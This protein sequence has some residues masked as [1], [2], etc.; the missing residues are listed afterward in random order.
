MRLFHGRSALLL[1]PLIFALPLL[2]PALLPGGPKALAQSPTSP[3]HAASTTAGAS[4][5]DAAG[6]LAKAA[7]AVSENRL[8]DARA[9][10]DAVKAQNS[11]QPGL[12]TAYAA[13]SL[14]EGD[15]A[16]AGADCRK[17]LALYPARWDAYRLL[18]TAEL[19]AG[20]QTEAIATLRAW[21]EADAANPQP[22]AALVQMLLADGKPAEALREGNAGLQRLPETVRGDPELQ[23]ALGAGELQAGDRAKGTSMLLA[24]LRGTEDSAL[25][26]SVAYLL[27]D[28]HLELPL[29]EST[30]REVIDHMT[31]LSEGWTLSEPVPTLRTGTAVLA[32]A[33][34]TLG[35]TLYREHKL[36]AAEAYVR[37]AWRNDLFGNDHSIVG[38]HLG[39]IEAARGDHRAALADYELTL[40][41]LAQLPKGSVGTEPASARKAALAA[42]IAAEHK[43]SGAPAAAASGPQTEEAALARLRLIKL[44]AGGGRNGTARYRLLF[45]RGKVV[46]VLL[47]HGSGDTL[48]Q[49]AELLRHIDAAAFFPVDSYAQVAHGGRLTCRPNGCE[50][51]VEY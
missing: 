23:Y 12:W 7:R 49:A 29:A 38:E 15:A 35:W 1:F 16:V 46:Q 50:L 26:S 3:G 6:L 27:A 36:A 51:A 33:W 21:A 10:L 25:R 34:D 47:E 20:Q 19:Q 40:A 22:V 13:L 28:A 9:S 44:G 11:A 14:R 17:E 42:K 18:V 4:Q 30:V 45:G 2:L 37:A 24:V 39:D 41:M 32:A 48:P 31:L 43:A 5:E 8:A